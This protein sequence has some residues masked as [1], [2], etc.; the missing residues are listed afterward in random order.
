MMPLLPLSCD[1]VLSSG[2]TFQWAHVLY[3]ICLTALSGPHS[4]FQLLT[5]LSAALYSRSC[6]ESCFIASSPVF[7]WTLYWGFQPHHLE[8]A[9]VK[10]IRLPIWPSSSIWYVALFK[11]LNAWVSRILHSAAVAA[12]PSCA[13]GSSS[14]FCPLTV[15]YCTSS[16]FCLW[17][18][19]PVFLSSLMALHRTCTDDSTF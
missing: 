17:F 12:L 7:L 13:G 5:S 11:T 15:D 14:L 2:S 3:F 4:F 1:S 6:W 10:T 9:V 18:P 8:T 16:L 19:D